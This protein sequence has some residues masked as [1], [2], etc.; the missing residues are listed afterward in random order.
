M[1][2]ANM[3]NPPRSL[4]NIATMFNDD[5]VLD[6]R[7]KGWPR[8]SLAMSRRPSM[9]YLTIAS[10]RQRNTRQRLQQRSCLNRQQ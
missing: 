5:P 8:H 3:L 4:R 2:A 6:H 1:R 10:S 7:T 9:V